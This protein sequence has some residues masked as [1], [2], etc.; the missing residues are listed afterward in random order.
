M[1]CWLYLVKSFM[2][3]LVVTVLAAGALLLGSAL[4]AGAQGPGGRGPGMGNPEEMAKM[5]V[6]RMKEALKLNEKQEAQLLDL[7]KQESEEMSKMFQSGERPDRE[8]MEANRKKQDEAI[9]K[10]LTEDQYKTYTEQ[11]QRRGGPG[12][13]GRGPGGPGRGPGGPG[14][15]RGNV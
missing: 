7:F 14:G 5:R 2:K 8:A 12:G 11:M 3:R 6:E 13:P 10:I 1:D 9:K 4:E 15:P